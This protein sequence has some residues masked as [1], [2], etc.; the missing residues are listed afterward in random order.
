MFSGCQLWYKITGRGVANDCDEH[1]VN[2]RGKAKKHEG[3]FRPALGGDE[4]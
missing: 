4:L 1:Q 2:M 3:R